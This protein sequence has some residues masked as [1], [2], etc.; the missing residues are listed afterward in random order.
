MR[1]THGRFRARDLFAS[2]QLRAVSLSCGPLSDPGPGGNPGEV[3]VA[4][5]NSTGIASLRAGA[6]GDIVEV[7]ADG[8]RLRRGREVLREGM[9][10]FDVEL[11]QA[12]AFGGEVVD[13]ETGAPIAAASILVG[14]GMGVTEFG[15][16]DA[17]GRFHI[18]GV[19]PS[20]HLRVIVRARGYLPLMFARLYPVLESN[21]IL[22]YI[23][24]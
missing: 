7:L 9:Y 17:R 20:V 11:V 10:E 4:Q 8:Y 15:P 3:S 14:S 21:T 18:P 16:S 13:A 23:S 2:A 12:V 1:S 5:T 19:E 6:P 22:I 24:C